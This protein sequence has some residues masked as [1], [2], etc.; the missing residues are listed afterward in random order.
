[1]QQIDKSHTNEWL[2]GRLRVTKNEMTASDRL[3]LSRL[4]RKLPAESALHRSASHFLEVGDPSPDFA[5]AVESAIEIGSG[6]SIRE[7]ILAV[8]LAS[9]AAGDGSAAVERS[10]IQILDSQPAPDSSVLHALWIFCF[11]PFVTPLS[12][13]IEQGRFNRVRAAA[14]RSLGIIGSVAAIDALSRGLHDARGVARTWAC[15]SVRTESGRALINLLPKLG[16]HARTRLEL[17]TVP[18]LARALPGYGEELSLAI[19]GAFHHIAGGEAV[20]AVEWASRRSPSLA[21]RAAA[22]ELLPHLLRRKREEQAATSLLRAAE[23]D[24]RLRAALDDPT[25]WLRPSDRAA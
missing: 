6:A 25:R 12:P 5:L 13:I 21:V 14:A 2:G 17:E 15:T 19:I 1:M 10:L 16:P 24:N 23:P 9:F 8:E 22:A 3:R 20:R 7:R 4:V 18:N 11:F